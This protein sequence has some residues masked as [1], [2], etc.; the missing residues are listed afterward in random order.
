MQT[1]VDTL[2]LEDFAILDRVIDGNKAAIRWRAT[3]H[4]VTSGQSYTT[5]LADF[6]E[7]EDGKLVSC[8]E[9][10]DTALAG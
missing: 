8:T 1:I 4:L 10:L 6:L 9:F 7:L 2:A 5:E 3:V